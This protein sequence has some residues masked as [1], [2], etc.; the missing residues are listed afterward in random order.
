MKDMY[1]VSSKVYTDYE[2]T[3][4]VLENRK[5]ETY[6]LK[7]IDNINFNS[8]GDLNIA[9]IVRNAD[10]LTYGSYDDEM[11]KDFFT[12]KYV[13][14]HLASYLDLPAAL[15]DYITAMRRLDKGDQQVALSNFSDNLKMFM[16]FRIKKQI[17]SSRMRTHYITVFEDIFGKFARIIRSELYRPYEDSNALTDF[18]GNLELINKNSN[19]N[20]YFKRARIS[21]FRSNFEYL[22]DTSKELKLVNVGDEMG[23]GVVNFNSETKDSSNGYQYLL[24]RLACLNGL[25]S[26]FKDSEIK[27]RHMGDDFALRSQKGFLKTLKLGDTFTKM[28]SDLDLK[29]KKISNN[30]NDLLT[31]P[32][33]L[34]AMKKNDKKELINIAQQEEYVFSP[35]G[36]V[37]ALTFKS[38]HRT[39]SDNDFNTFNDKA[40]KI[41]RNVKKVNK[42][43]PKSKTITEE[44]ILPKTTIDITDFDLV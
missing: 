29:S 8:K 4:K 26:T 9:Y 39:N 12:P 25:V 23:A 33:E 11:I 44:E 27:I 38:N 41:M 20:Y 35:Y 2:S 21:P 40:V 37:Q 36:I 14:N 3:V 42:W 7:G 5:R 30:W 19:S 28:F 43:S 13:F 22:D 1:S 24:M 16:N 15:Y 32:S 31:I 17:E 10:D 34:L 6:E 18:H